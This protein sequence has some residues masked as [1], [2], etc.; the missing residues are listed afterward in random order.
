MGR[1]AVGGHHAIALVAGFRARYLD[2]VATNGPANPASANG[3]GAGTYAEAA[4]RDPGRLRI[5]ACAGTPFPQ[6]IA[7]EQRAAFEATRTL[8]A[9]LGHDVEEVSMQYLAVIPQVVARYLRA[10]HDDV[11]ELPHPERLERRTRGMARLG[12]LIAPPIWAKAREAEGAAVVRLNRVLANHDVLLTP[13]LAQ[14]PLP[15]GRYE[16]RGALYT[17]NGVARFTPYTAAWNVTGQ[18]AAAVPA[19]FT[20][21]GVPLSIQLVGR[22]HDE[23][24]LLSLSAQL[25]AA[26]PWAERRPPIAA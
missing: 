10:I 21:A 5:A 11:V 9:S 18:P 23:A 3:R 19:G 25:E 20:D 13:A 15:I 24:T 4:Q 12:S 2:V 16:G 7:R 1:T 26:R 6:P 22:P 8:L 17:F 14:L